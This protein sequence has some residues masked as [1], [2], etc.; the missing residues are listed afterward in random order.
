MKVIE[1]L[2]EKHK[3]IH[4][5]NKDV[6]KVLLFAWHGLGDIIMLM[7]P[8]DKLKELYPDI[9]F[10]L[11]LAKGL[12]QEEIYKDALLVEAGETKDFSGDRFKD[13][14][15][16][17][18]INMPMNESQTQYTKGEWC[19]IHELGINPVWGHRKPNIINNRLVA[20]HFQITCLPGSA[21]VPS[22]IAEKVWK[23]IIDSEYI[24]IETL[25]EHT[26]HNPANKKYDFI[27]R[28][29][30]NIKPKISTLAGLI[31]NC[32]AFI[33]G[34]SGNFHVA[35]SVLPPERIC[36]L[37]KDFTAPSFTKHD[38]KRINIKEYKDGEIKK[39]I[40]NMR[41]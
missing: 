23:E 17:A 36:L 11:A 25:M 3:L 9:H 41:I 28:H 14:D 7:K 21:T 27:D 40:Q 26:F 15:V 30:R 32:S 1:P 20:C 39:W 4:Y 38:I 13:Y 12:G 33:G 16:I 35:L 34:V 31:Q 2:K 37:E 22:N 18:R 24:P 5:L 29:V 6:K 8:F 19:C 10:D